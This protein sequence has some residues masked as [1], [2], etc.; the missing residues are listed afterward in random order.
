MEHTLRASAPGTVRAF[1]VQAG[2]SVSEGTLLVDFE[3][4]EE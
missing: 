4:E 3:T 1:L 2:D